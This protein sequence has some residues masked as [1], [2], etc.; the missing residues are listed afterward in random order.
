M[1]KKSEPAPDP[2]VYLSTSEGRWRVISQGVPLCADTD[3][4]TARALAARF[5]W[6]ISHGRV[7]NG[8]K[9]EWEVRT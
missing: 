9:G 4:V 8:D 7:W 1:K 2:R 6:D 3:E 5:K